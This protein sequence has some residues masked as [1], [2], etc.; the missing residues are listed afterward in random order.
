MNLTITNRELLRNYKKFRQRLVKG[1][2]QQ[3]LIEQ[4]DGT[5]L[6][7]VVENKQT[8]FQRMVEIARKHQLHV[9][10]P[11]EDLFDERI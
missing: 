10:R 8:P 5:T 4:K 2:V 1:Q 11:K 9:E 7:L 6:K 3:I